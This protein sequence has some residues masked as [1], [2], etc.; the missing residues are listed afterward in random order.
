MVPTRQEAYD[1]L[2][3]YTQ[4][5]SLVRHGLAVEAVMRHFARKYGEDEEKWGIIGLVHDLDWEMYPEQHCAKTREILEEAGW[6]QEYIRS[7]MSHAW[8]FVT[9]VKPE[10]QMEKV[11]YA[12]DELTGLVNATALMRPSRS[13]LDMKAKSVKK[14]WKDKSFAA[15]VDR[16]VIARG[17]EMLGMEIEELITETIEAMRTVSDEIGLR[18]E[19]PAGE[20]SP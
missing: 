11:L 17:A 10:E 19:V 4:S 13:V 7:I 12:T 16:E 15:G 6:P 3:A 18:G 20:G 9:D 1:L 8:G 5:E 2:T 14:K